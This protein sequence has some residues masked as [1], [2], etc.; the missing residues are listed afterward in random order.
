M[1]KYFNVTV[2]VFNSFKILKF[3]HKTHTLIEFRI[4]IKNVCLLMDFQF[5]EI[6]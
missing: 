2:I 5:D 6:N 3:I 4:Q 1:V